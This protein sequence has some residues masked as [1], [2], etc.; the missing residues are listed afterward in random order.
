MK[1]SCKWTLLNQSSLLK[2]M[3]AM[4]GEGKSGHLRKEALFCIW[5]LLCD[6][7]DNP[8]SIYFFSIV[9]IFQIF[10][11]LTYILESRGSVNVSKTCRSTKC[12]Y[13]AIY[14]LWDRILGIYPVWPYRIDRN[15]PFDQNRNT[16]A[17]GNKHGQSNDGS[18]TS[19]YDI[20]EQVL[21]LKFTFMWKIKLHT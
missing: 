3:V 4:I 14:P 20:N 18:D 2:K 13:I 5:W 17:G 21:L 7:L 9:C 16:L 15:S 8:P 12:Q 19:Y 10:V 6:F 1:K 11:F